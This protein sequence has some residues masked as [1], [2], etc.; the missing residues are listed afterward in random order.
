MLRRQNVQLAIRPVEISGK[1]CQQ[2]KTEPP[3]GI[4]GARLDPRQSNVGGF[5]QSSFFEQLGHAHGY[6]LTLVSAILDA[7]AVLPASKQRDS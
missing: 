2:G 7:D 6:V 5:G 3:V 1:T 4:G